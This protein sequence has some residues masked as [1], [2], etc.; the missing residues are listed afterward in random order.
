MA[1]SEYIYVHDYTRCV[2]KLM[3]CSPTGIREYMYILDFYPRC[4]KPKPNH[5]R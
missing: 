1:L 2:Y 5:L 4:T 3:Q